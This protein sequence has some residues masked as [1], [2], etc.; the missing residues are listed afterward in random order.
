MA[1]MNTVKDMKD[2]LCCISGDL[3]KAGNG[4]KAAS[5]RV[6]TCTI[7]FEKM[8]K[9][10][11]KESIAGERKGGGGKKKAAKP[12]AKKKAAPKKMKKPAKKKAFPSAKPA[13]WAPAKKPTAKIPVKKA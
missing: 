13:V 6:R 12:A 2:L 1:L 3:E 7:K 11:R 5:Q 4:N 8:A 9:R 10:Y